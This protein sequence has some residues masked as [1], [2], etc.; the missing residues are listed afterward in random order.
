MQF[1]KPLWNMQF[2]EK[3]NISC[4]FVPLAGSNPNDSRN[5]LKHGDYYHGWL[6]KSKGNPRPK[7]FCKNIGS[8]VS[9]ILTDPQLVRDM[10]IYKDEFI[11][12][13]FQNALVKRLSPNGLVLL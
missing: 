13:P 9:L 8:T 7:L 6:K 11:K 10:F 1:I 3:Q 4:E 12:H 5:I 2:Y